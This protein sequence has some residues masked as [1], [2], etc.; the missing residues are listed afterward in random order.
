M[1]AV[2]LPLQLWDGKQLAP[3]FAL[4]HSQFSADAAGLRRTEIDD[5]NAS[6]IGSDAYHALSAPATQI[7]PHAPVVWR[8][9]GHVGEAVHLSCGENVVFHADFH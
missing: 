9:F 6:S 4:D 2:I 5:P 1:P 8:Q 7:Q 3:T